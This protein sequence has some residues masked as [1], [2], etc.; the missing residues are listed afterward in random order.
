MKRHSIFFLVPYLVYL[1]FVLGQ[2]GIEKIS[3]EKVPNW[4]LIQFS[5]TFIG[6]SKTF[7]LTS[8]YA[9]A[10]LELLTAGLLFVGLLKIFLDTKKKNQ[11]KNNLTEATEAILDFG[12]L[13]AFV[14]FLILSLGQRVSGNFSGASEVLT[15]AV[16]TLVVR[17]AFLQQKNKDNNVSKLFVSNSRQH[18]I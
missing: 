15:Y 10:V 5:S 9:I 13:S 4:F 1:F 11:Q 8:F 17:L 12:L 14:T 6:S 7:L 16:V 18:T 2:A 3:V